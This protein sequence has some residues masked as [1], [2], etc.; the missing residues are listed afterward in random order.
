MAGGIAES[1][2]ARYHAQGRVAGNAVNGSCR[3]IGF[4][5]LAYAGD[6]ESCGDT[7]GERH[8][9]AVP[10]TEGAEPEEHG[11]PVIAIDVTF[12]DRRPDL[13]RRRRVLVPCR[14]A[15][16]RGERWHR[17]RAV[18]VDP[19]VQQFRVHVNGRDGDGHRQ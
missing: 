10:G 16:A 12:D 4:R 5:V 9:D 6:A 2:A 13:A 8:V 3:E 15:R 19:Q 1:A 18:R 11:W 17:Y 14:L 7:V